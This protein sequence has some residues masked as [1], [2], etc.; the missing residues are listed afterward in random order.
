VT[1]YRRDRLAAPPSLN[2]GARRRALVRVG[3]LEGVEFEEFVAAV[4]GEPRG[5]RIGVDHAPVLKNKDC[6]VERLG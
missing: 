2:A 5:G 4:A 3:Q 1:R 6:G